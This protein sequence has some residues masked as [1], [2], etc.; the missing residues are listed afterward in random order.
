MENLESVAAS[1]ADMIVAGS[2]IFHS[3]DAR[4]TTRMMVDRLAAMAERERSV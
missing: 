2:A 3:G 1:G 4:E